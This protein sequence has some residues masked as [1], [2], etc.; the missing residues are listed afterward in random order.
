M[1]RRDLGAT[2]ATL[3]SLPWFATLPA[4]ATDA[5][6]VTAA[7]HRIVEG[8][9]VFQGVG[10]DISVQSG[11]RHGNG[12]FVVGARGV[13]VIDAGV[14][15]RH[16]VERLAAIR[17][18]TSLPIL[19]V[20]LTHAMQEFIFGASAFQAEGIPVLM[21]KDAAQLMAARCETCLKTLK[22]ELGEETMQASRV[23]KADRIFSTQGEL[24]AALPDIG[25]ALR[26]IWTEPRSQSASPGATAVFDVPSA[27]LFAGAMLDAR[28]IPDLQ[29][30]DLQ[31]WHAARG[32][33]R[34][35]RPTVVVPGR[36]PVG[37]AGLIDTV[38]TYLAELQRQ[39][40]N[41]LT[42]GKPLS[43][44]A[45]SIELPAYA[46]YDRYETTHR[47]NVSILYLRQERAMMLRS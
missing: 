8:V 14:S 11:A 12:G 20:L 26:M 23:P 35:L 2:L 9:W 15:H 33:L 24:Q 21:H 39:V 22:R 38:E 16:G 47:R 7:P 45:D 10:G 29:D 41:Y 3:M 37:D 13:F 44:A 30:A 27:T 6:A 28:T 17:R 36:G 46:G 32:L 4:C 42:A 31:Q 34:A 40:D 5:G 25:R 19:G 18:V 43:D 1:R